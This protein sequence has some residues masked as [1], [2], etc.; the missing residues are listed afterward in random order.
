[1]AKLSGNL[2]AD[3]SPVVRLVDIGIGLSNAIKNKQ[4]K[5]SV[6]ADSTGEYY[7]VSDNNCPKSAERSK[8]LPNIYSSTPAHKN[9]NHL[10]VLQKLNLTRISMGGSPPGRTLDRSEAS[11]EVPQP[12]RPLHPATDIIVID[13]SY[14][15]TQEVTEKAVPRAAKDGEVP[16]QAAVTKAAPTVNGIPTATWDPKNKILDHPQALQC[17][18]HSQ[19]NQVPTTGCTPVT[20]I[21]VQNVESQSRAVPAALSTKSAVPPLMNGNCGKEIV[22]NSPSVEVT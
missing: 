20:A 16:R 5:V 12:R 14:V 11:Y 2:K 4:V 21:V 9:P 19:N 6:V 3:L 7:S 13:D 10:L 17:K 18:P 22:S 15:G 8:A 1:M